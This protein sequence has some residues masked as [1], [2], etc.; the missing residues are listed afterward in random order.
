MPV[1]FVVA[2]NIPGPRT[3]RITHV[4]NCDRRLFNAGHRDKTVI[5]RILNASDK[6]NVL[7]QILIPALADVPVFNVRLN[8]IITLPV[9]PPANRI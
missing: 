8:H 1:I 9:H 4:V 2:V 6:F 7:R 5:V 3:V